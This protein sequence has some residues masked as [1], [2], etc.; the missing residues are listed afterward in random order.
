MNSNF[1]VDPACPGMHHQS[2]YAALRDPVVRRLADEAVFAASKLFAAYGRLNEITRAVEMADDCGQSVAIV[3]RARI[4]DLL[5]RHDVMRQHK[6]DLDRFAADQ[7]ERFRVDI[8]R[9]TALLINAPRKI[10]AL[11][12]EVRTY[13]QARAK[14]A[15]KLSEAGLDAEAIQRAGVK[16]D[17]SDLAEWARA[18]ETAERDLQIAREFLAGAPL[19]HAELLSGLSNG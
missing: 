6:A 7:R 4:G 16:P 8:A 17:E 5:S 19:Y 13:D 2:L 1:A 15:E 14:F 11:Q 10:E 12:M 9:C 18:I 3:L